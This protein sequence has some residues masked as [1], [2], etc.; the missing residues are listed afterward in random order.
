MK[1]L[2]T[3]YFSLLLGSIG[4]VCFLCSC[5][6]RKPPKDVYEAYTV[7]PPP[8]YNLSSSWAARPDMEDEA[9]LTPPGVSPENQQ[10]AKVDVFFIHPTSWLKDDGW[11]ATLSDTALNRRTDTYVIKNQATIFNASCK[12]YAP[13]YRQMSLGGFYTDDL[14]SEQKAL[15]LAYEDVRAAFQYYLTHFN[16][17]RP[18]IIAAHS[19]GTYHGIRLVKEF[20]DGQ[21]LQVKL[22]AAYLAGWPWPENTLSS[23]P[24]C[25]SPDQTGCAMAWATYVKGAFP[26]NYDTFYQNSF[27]INPITWTRDTME[28][29]A[30]AH[31]GFLMGN[32][33]EIRRK[34]LSSQIAGRIL[35][36][37]NPFKVNPR[38]NLH[39]G[40][41]NL[42]WVDIRKNVALRVESYLAEQE[43]R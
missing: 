33:E 7:P 34:N 39:I 12:V 16:Q 37:D 3:A 9:D 26:K 22:V 11:N 29:S 30:E 20:F 23:I 2:D 32:F 5:S 1:R 28:V 42:F 25:E 38:R 19:Q 4:I 18:M 8:D 43:G 13:R 17:G 10:G 27:S 35:W 21:P 31:Q 6:A 36:V 40:D 15:D 14:A 41:Y 24:I